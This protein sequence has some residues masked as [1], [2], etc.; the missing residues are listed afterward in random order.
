MATPFQQAAKK[1]RT[2][3]ALSKQLPVSNQDIVATV[4]HALLHTPSSFNSQSTRTLVLFGA[5]HDKLWQKTAEIL[6]TIVNDELKFAATAKKIAGFKAGVGTILFFEDRIVIADLQARFPS[7]ADGFATWADHANAMHQYAIWVALAEQNVGANLQH[8][9][10]LID[11]FIQEQWD[12]NSDWHLR[13]Q[14]VFGG[15]AQPAGEKTFG[16]IDERMKIAGL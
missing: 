7:Y 10:P 4:E 6:R 2:I 12:I 15:I 13:A 5:E 11:E 9:N 8:Y 16:A 1:R 14:M 3:Y